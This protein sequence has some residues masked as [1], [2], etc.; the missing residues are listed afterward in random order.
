MESEVRELKTT[1][2]V[3]QALR[4]AMEELQRKVNSG[5]TVPMRE[6]T[7]LLI[8]AKETNGYEFAREIEKDK[9]DGWEIIEHKWCDIPVKDFEIPSAGI[10]K[11][12]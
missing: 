9:R 8:W 4:T 11:K 12:N 6:F 10:H 2:L 5:H 7:N 3:N 1:A